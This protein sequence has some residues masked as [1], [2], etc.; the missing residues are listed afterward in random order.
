[1]KLSDNFSLSIAYDS[2]KLKLIGPIPRL[3]NL[4]HFPK[5]PRSRE[6]LDV[7]L[8]SAISSAR[9]QLVPGTPASFSA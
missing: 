1:M 4:L 7:F 5:E 3:K 8:I 9:F 6:T 2:D